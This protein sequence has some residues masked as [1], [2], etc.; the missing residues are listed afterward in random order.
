MKRPARC[1]TA[2]NAGERWRGLFP[3]CAVVVFPLALLHFVLLL[4]F[5]WHFSILC[6][7]CVSI[8]LFPFCAAV[9]FTFHA[10][11]LRGGSYFLRV[12]ALLHIVLLLCCLHWHCSILCCC[13]VYVGCITITCGGFI[14]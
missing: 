4:C 8:G 5:H 13:C 14:R 1:S 12:V 6:C 7:C 2:A 9:V 10:L 11:L 3:F